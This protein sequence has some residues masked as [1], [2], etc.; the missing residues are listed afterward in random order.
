LKLNVEKIA[1]S[2]HLLLVVARRRTNVAIAM[3][4]AALAREVG[5][6]M[7][8]STASAGGDSQRLRGIPAIGRGVPGA[9][10]GSRPD[11]FNGRLDPIARRLAELAWDIDSTSPGT[12]PEEAYL[13]KEAAA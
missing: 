12:Q 9:M 4:M 5:E 8:L 1:Y 13:A 10:R 7:P 6:S 3:Q 2:G 11:V